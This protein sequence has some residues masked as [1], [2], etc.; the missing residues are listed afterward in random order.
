MTE[1]RISVRMMGTVIDIMVDAQDGFDSSSIIADVVRKLNVYERRFSAN[2]PESELMKV[3]Q[4]SGVAPVN[5]QPDLYHLIKKGKEHS[6][7]K[8]SHLNIALGPLIKAWHIGFDDAKRPAHKD[9]IKALKLTNPDD[10]KMNDDQLTVFLEKKGM[11]IDL[12]ALA[13]GYIADLIID[14]LKLQP[15]RTA[16][17]NLGGNFLSF[18]SSKTRAS[19]HYRI[20]IQDPKRERN[21]YL[22]AVDTKNQSV[23]TSGIYERTLKQND[24][25]FHHIFD[26]QTGYPVDTELASLTIVSPKSVD[27]EIWTTRLFGHS[28]ETL[29][30]TVE[31]LSDI[32]CIL[33]TKANTLHYSKGLKDHII[34]LPS[35]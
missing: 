11:Q 7:K 12:G 23:V 32:E 10:I 17:I 27:G 1:Q 31:K 24:E 6:L 34:T 16:F 4:A 15:V 30:A 8:D 9:I 20:G 28:I 21:T 14:D 22:L 19:G 25:T 3:N 2:D 18:G 26:Q 29:L 33:I 5:V 35:R 13:K